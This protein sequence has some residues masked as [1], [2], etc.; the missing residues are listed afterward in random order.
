M[1]STTFMPKPCFQFGDKESALIYDVFKGE[2]L[3][4]CSAEG[5]RSL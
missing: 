4:E 3:S 5:S 1:L 2:Y